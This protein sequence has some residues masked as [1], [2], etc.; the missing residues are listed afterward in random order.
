MRS[1]PGRHTATLTL[2]ALPLLF[3]PPAHAA[4]VVVYGPDA[5]SPERAA[6]AEAIYRIATASDE[7]PAGGVAHVLDLP[8]PSQ[9]PVWMAGD[10]LQLPCVDSTLAEFDPTEALEAGIAHI[11]ELDYEKAL[12]EIEQGIRALPCT[13]SGVSRQTLIDLH[14]FQAMAHFDLGNQTK[15]RR[16]FSAALAVH[17]DMPWKTEYPPAPQTVFLEAKSALLSRGTTTLGIDVSGAGIESLSVDGN[18]VTG[19]SVTELVLYRGRHLVRYVDR[20]GASHAALVDVGQNGGALI[21][22]EALRGAVLA[23]AWGGVGA[24]AGKIALADLARNRGADRAIVVI[25]GGDDRDH[26][27]FSF[28]VSDAT[29]VPLAVDSEAVAALLSGKK[30]RP[31]RGG[32]AAGAPDTGEAGRLGLVLGGG[33]L[34][35]ANTPYGMGA[36]R[37]H[38]RLVQGLEIGVGGELGATAADGTII[39]LPNALLDVRYRLDVGDHFHPYFGGRGW[40]SFSHGQEWREDVRIYVLGA[41]G[42]TFGFDV[43]PGGT[44]GFLINLDV[45]VGVGGT[46]GLDTPQLHLT[47]G[48]GVGFRL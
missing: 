35:S 24:A 31:G 44:K 48:G 36:L 20:S 12:L 27:A 28:N 8:F 41:G 15:A 47:V 6:A 21:S 19:G 37:V 26:R 39:L 14:F 43:T 38:L 10:L 16:G 29:M 32:G 40:L 46:A 18:D 5:P 7:S 45:G 33:L 11:D 42:G 17:I 22:R 4:D 13:A 1:L 34:L 2:L 25:P 23:L 3:S 9:D 30:K